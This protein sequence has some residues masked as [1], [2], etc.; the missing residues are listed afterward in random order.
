[1]DACDILLGR[2]WLF[3]RGVKHDGKLNTYTFAKDHKKITLTPLKPSQI[4]K[5]KDSPQ[6]DVF[7]TTLLRSQQREFQSA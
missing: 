4:Q 5:P 1:M 2:P 7:L 3:D 6:L